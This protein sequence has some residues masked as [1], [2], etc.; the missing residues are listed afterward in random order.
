[1]LSVS[2]T[3]SV[4]RHIHFTDSLVTTHTCRKQMTH[5]DWEKL[6]WTLIKILAGMSEQ[7]PRKTTEQQHYP[8][9]KGQRM[10][11]PR[12]AWSSVTKEL[13]GS[14][15]TQSEWGREEQLIGVPWSL[16]P[17]GSKVARVR[18]HPTRCRE[19]YSFTW[20]TLAEDLDGATGITWSRSPPTYWPDVPQPNPAGN[21]EDK[22]EPNQ[23]QPWSSGRTGKGEVSLTMNIRYSAFYTPS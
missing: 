15:E 19:T 23:S 3:N 7:P 1:M 9:R 11:M 13:P 6:K 2:I 18:T 14:P 5:S 12:Q 4:I 22:K 17:K 21:P 20:N 16:L 8:N 10:T